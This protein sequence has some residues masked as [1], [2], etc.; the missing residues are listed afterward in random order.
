VTDEHRS[1]ADL[2]NH[3]HHV[4]H[5][6]INTPLAEHLMPLAA[7]MP[8]QGNRVHGPTALGKPIQKML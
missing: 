7:P 3:L 6:V 5:V 1:F 8:T 2:I 4:G